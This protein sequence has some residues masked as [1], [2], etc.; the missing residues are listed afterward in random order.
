MAERGR[1]LSDAAL[2]RELVALGRDVDFPPAPALAAAVRR[3]LALTG[4]PRRPRL[5]AAR[6]LALALAA[7]LL[8]G[9]LLLA[10]SPGARAAL[11]GRLGVRGIGISQVPFVPTA[12]PTATSRPTP[13][14]EPSAAAGSATPAATPTPLPAG[15]RLGLGDALPTDDARCLAGAPLPVPQALGPPDAT[16]VQAAPDCAV[17]LL[18]RPRPGLPATAET[19][20]GLL[21][22]E[23]RGTTDERLVAAK[24]VGPDTRLERVTV[25]GRP[26]FWLEGSPHLFFYRGADGKVRDDTLRLAG[27]T[28]IWEHGDRTLRLEAN[29]GR[30]AA[31]AIAAS[32]P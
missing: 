13:T 2:E 9:A 32:V 8:L 27:N 28:L 20:V 22:I 19:G 29:L 12:L 7:A 3:R 23:L 25:G 11:A 6:R 31:L 30:D 21:L 18:Y 17:A 15:A 1:P 16:Y 10:A 4:P 14:R 5:P 24:G 26:G